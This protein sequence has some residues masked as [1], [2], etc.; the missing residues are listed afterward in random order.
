MTQI[1]NVWNSS[2]KKLEHYSCNE[3]IFEIGQI[4]VYKQNSNCFLF[5]K[6]N[7]SITQLAGFNKQFALDLHENSQT[8]ENKFLFERASENYLKGL[9]LL[10]K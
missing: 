10:N 4:K 8:V 1:L 2:P 9:K 3:P 5:T 6:N 7:I